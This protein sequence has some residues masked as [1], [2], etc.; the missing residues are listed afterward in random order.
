MLTELPPDLFRL[1]LDLSATHDSHVNL[2]CRQASL[3][4]RRIS[5]LCKFV[6]DI[7]TNEKDPQYRDVESCKTRQ[8]RR[9]P[10]TREYNTEEIWK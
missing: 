8:S 1:V 9:C 10:R 6:N 5:W 3:E 7:E 4:C 2:S